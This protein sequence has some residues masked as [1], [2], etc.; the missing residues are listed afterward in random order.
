MDSVVRVRAWGNACLAEGLVCSCGTREDFGVGAIW[1]RYVVDSNRQE[2]LDDLNLV[3]LLSTK[4][5]LRCG[6]IM[7]RDQEGSARSSYS[8]PMHREC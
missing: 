3:A 8:V 7:L 1:W 6:E 4:Y 2:T 5:S